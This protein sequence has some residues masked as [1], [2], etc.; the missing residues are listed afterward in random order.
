[1]SDPRTAVFLFFFFL[2]RLPLLQAGTAN[3]LGV[4]GIDVPLREFQ[5]VAHP[6]K[7]S[8]IWGSVSSEVLF[9]LCV[10][11]PKFSLFFF[12]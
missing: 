3:L 6:F 8:S 1:M 5:K 2:F 9:R 11:S 12:I 7:V 4:V 10:R